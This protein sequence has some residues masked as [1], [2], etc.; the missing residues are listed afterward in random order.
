MFVVRAAG[1]YAQLIDVPLSFPVPW[2][3]L[4]AG[5]TCIHAAR[6]LRCA[7]PGASTNCGIA[8]MHRGLADDLSFSTIIYIILDEA[9][10]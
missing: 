4:R 9:Q 10:V 8:D 2:T 5:C 6:T 1:V 3:L 7:G